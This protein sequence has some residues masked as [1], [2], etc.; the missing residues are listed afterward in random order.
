MKGVE[1]RLRPI[2]Y[3]PQNFEPSERQIR[4]L[5]AGTQLKLASQWRRHALGGW[6]R[7][8]EG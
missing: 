6:H 7:V 2:D 8:T 4:R 5:E 3:R 1:R